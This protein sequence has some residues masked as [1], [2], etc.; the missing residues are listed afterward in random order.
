MAKATCEYFLTTISAT[1]N[2][3]QALG[4]SLPS[5]MPVPSRAPDATR[6]GLPLSQVGSQVAAVSDY[7]AGIFGTAGSRVL[8]RLDQSANVACWKL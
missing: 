4:P 7:V 6:A 2:E 8:T 5:S 1:G 3:T